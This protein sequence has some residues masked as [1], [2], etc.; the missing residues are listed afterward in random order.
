MIAPLCS[1]ACA[2]PSVPRSRNPT[3]R[4]PSRNMSAPAAFCIAARS[5]NRM[6]SG[7]PVAL[8]CLSKCSLLLDVGISHRRRDRRARAAAL[9]PRAL[10]PRA[11]DSRSIVIDIGG[12]DRS[13]R[14]E[15]VFIR[16]APIMIARRDGDYCHEQLIAAPEHRRD[17]RNRGFFALVRPPPMVLSRHR[18][19][20]L[21]RLS[22]TSAASS[23]RSETGGEPIIRSARAAGGA[24]A[25]SHDAASLWRDARRRGTGA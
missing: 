4:R 18:P 2:K 8:F 3:A 22:V 5:S 9:S 14:S 17:R 24:G 12:L 21:G 25:R 19:D 23:A 1:A 6:W 16:H 10:R 20:R 7:A 15:R 11:S 13:R